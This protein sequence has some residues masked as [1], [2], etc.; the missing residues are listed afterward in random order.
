LLQTGG[1]RTPLEHEVHQ[2]GCIGLL[3]HLHQRLDQAV[4]HAYGWPKDV[5]AQAAVQA[6]VIL[7]R[8]RR[9]EEE[10]GQFRFLRPDYQASRIGVA[11]RP[12]QAEADLSVEASLPILPDAPGP[13]AV[14]LLQALRSEG[15]PVGPAALASRFSG[16]SGRRTED[17]IA[18]TLA[19]LAVAG[20]VQRTEHGWFAPRRS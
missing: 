7:N 6:L 14:A 16:R 4:N 13:L 3:D 19:V 10:V 11:H 8:Q 9:S 2:A 18:Q 1:P 20:T 17:R 15:L 5:S 12:R